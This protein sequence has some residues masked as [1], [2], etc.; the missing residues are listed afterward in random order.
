MQLL[1]F[2]TTDRPSSSILI[3][4]RLF[5]WLSRLFVIV[6]AVGEDV[7]RGGVLD[8]AVWLDVLF[9]LFAGGLWEAAF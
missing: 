2:N 8:S 7:L 5:D 3:L 9:G 4:L 1:T 6:L